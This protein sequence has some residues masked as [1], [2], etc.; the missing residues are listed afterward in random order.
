VESR[1]V[2]KAQRLSSA[3]KQGME[4]LLKAG[5]QVSVDGMG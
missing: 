1:Y 4:R 5:R 2:A 3:D